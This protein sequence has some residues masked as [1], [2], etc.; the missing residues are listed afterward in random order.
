MNETEV[1]EVAKKNKLKP[2][3]VSDPLSPV[4]IRLG[5]DLRAAVELEA[6]ERGVSLGEVC[7]ELIQDG[8]KDSPKHQHSQLLRSLAIAKEQL[9]RASEDEGRLPWFKGRPFTKAIDAIEDLE[10]FLKEA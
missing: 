9:K 2:V 3:T 4:G 6:E 8:M 7:R 5:E 10:E 1:Q